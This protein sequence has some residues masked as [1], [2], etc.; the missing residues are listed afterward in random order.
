MRS[1]RGPLIMHRRGP[2]K[3]GDKPATPDKATAGSGNVQR[4]AGLSPEGADLIRGE[5]LDESKLQDWD[6]AGKPSWKLTVEDS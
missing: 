5:K 2:G 6:H 4:A 1:G 3:E